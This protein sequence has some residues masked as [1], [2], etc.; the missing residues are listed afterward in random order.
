[1]ETEK[2][3][4]TKE[5]PE[6]NAKRK[7]ENLDSETAEEAIIGSQEKKEV[8]EK[9]PQKK[10]ETQKSH[11][12][13]E[14]GLKESYLR[15]AAEFENYQ[16]RVD[17]EKRDL[18]ESGGREAVRALLP[19]LDD[20]E[21]AIK[22]VKEGS[23]LMLLHKKL[24]ETL[25][26]EGLERIDCAGKFNPDLHEALMSEEC[27]KDEGEITRVISSGYKFRGKVLRYAKVCVSSGKNKGDE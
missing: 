3:K 4:E 17:K 10:E 23:G 9:E 1:M 16:K 13:H 26:K 7:K 15:L 24:M 8:S 11:H 14:E 6:E 22:D 25:Q 12:G 2:N 5:E 21:A 18:L 27:Q 19:L 20:F